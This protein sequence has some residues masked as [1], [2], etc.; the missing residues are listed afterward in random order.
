VKALK[1]DSSRM[2][3]HKLWFANFGVGGMKMDHIFS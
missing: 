1:T 3:F 2:V